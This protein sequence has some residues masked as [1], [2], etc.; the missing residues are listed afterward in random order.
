MTD[1]LAII[2]KEAKHV[3]YLLLENTL[4]RNGVKKKINGEEIR[5]PLEYSRYYPSDYES[6]KQAFIRR[7]ASGNCVDL[8]AHIG[9]YT[10]LMSRKAKQVIAFEPT[11]YTRKIFQKTLKLNECKNVKVRS[12]VVSDR[13][14]KSSFYD[15][16]KRVSNANSVVP[17]G[18]STQIESLALDDLRISIDFLKIDIEGSELMA[19]KGAKKV[20]STLKYMTIEIHP[21]LLHRLG[22]SAEEIFQLLEQFQ[23]VYFFEGR[24]ATPVELLKI[25]DHF[26]VNIALNGSNVEK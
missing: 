24:I 18:T 10:V 12:E 7:H 20:L 13:A 23:P 4:F 8:G 22:Q 5:F 21:S 14:G 1:F 19:L 26:E 11:D 2:R 3:M 25:T 6:F 16:G 9:L 15:T 17:V